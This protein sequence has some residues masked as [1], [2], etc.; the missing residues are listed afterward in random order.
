MDLRVKKMASLEAL[1]LTQ[2]LIE[3][4]SR[5][6][7]P[8][9]NHIRDLLQRGAD[10]NGVGSWAMTPIMFL[11]INLDE[12]ARIIIIEL[13]K[14][15]K[16]DLNAKDCFGA[17][18]LNIASHEGF[19]EVVRMLLKDGRVDIHAKDK[20]DY[21]ALISA[22]ENGHHEVVRILLEDDRMEVN[23]KDIDGRTALIAASQEGHQEIVRILLKDDRVEVN[24][25]D[26]RGRSAFFWANYCGSPNTIR[27]FLKHGR[28]DV[29]A[30]GGALGNTALIWACL[31]GQAA[32]VS[33][34]LAFPMLDV[35]AKNKAG[36]TALDIASELQMIET[37]RLMEVRAEF[38]RRR[39]L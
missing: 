21:T 32:I 5:D 18:A 14:H 25:K 3:E 10:I 39:D 20:Y 2:Q 6:R 30:A 1:T 23:A 9:I 8:D 15:E 4:V 31:R 19:Q 7:L 33:E 13:L 28:V 29:N 11:A 36:S 34:L 37:A 22:S 35:E 24:A 16:L 17:T 38:D 26:S 12:S 27:M